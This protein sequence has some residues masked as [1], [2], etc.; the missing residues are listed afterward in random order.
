MTFRTLTK[1]LRKDSNTLAHIFQTYAKSKQLY[2]GKQLHAQLITSGYPSSTYVT[3][4]ILSLYSKCGHIEYAH[5]VFDEMP[6]RN[7]VSWTAM[8]SAFSQNSEYAKAISMFCS[9]WVSGESANEFAFSSVIKACSFLKM[10]D[11]GR[12]VHCLALKV[13]LSYEMFVGS[14]LADMYSKCGSLVEACMVFEE[15]PVKDEV[16]WNSMI[17]GYAKNGC[18]EEALMAFRKMLDEDVSIDQHLLCSALCACGGGNVYNVGRC[19]HT[20]VVKLGFELNVSVGNALMD[21][22]CK[23]GDMD[24]GSRLLETDSRGTN[25]VSY[26]SLI[27]GYVEA[28]QIDKALTIFADLKRKNIE[29]NEFTFSSLIKACANQASLEQGVQLHALVFKYNLNQDPFVSSVIVDMYG[30]CGLLDQSIQAFNKISKANEYAWNSLM[31]VFAHHG[32][33]H[34]AIDVFNKMLVEKLKPNAVTFINL[35]NACSHSGLVKEGL[36]YFDSMK[37]VYKITP[38]SEHYSCVVDLLGRAGRLEEAENFI[39]MFC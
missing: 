18:Y 22:Y 24:S 16:S 29:P 32:L 36:S 8:I 14:N 13:G 1:H 9:M 39:G 11:V 31:G 20:F 3:N 33:G 2:N 38:R 19:L 30:K 25:I 6:Q 15:M 5:K 28:D 10:V 37:K 34:E 12:Q 35:L 4:H 27:D 21:M 17:D 7:L 26:T 23:I